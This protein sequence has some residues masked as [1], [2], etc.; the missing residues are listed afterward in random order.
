MIFNKWIRFALSAAVAALGI[1]AG[2]DW[3]SVVSPGAAGKIIGAIGMA[4]M[5]MDALAPA[6]GQPVVET[7]KTLVT[8]SA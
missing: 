8:H 7:G 5:A 6:V 4:K 2:L 3:S 1:A